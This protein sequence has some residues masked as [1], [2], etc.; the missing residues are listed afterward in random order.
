VR[1]SIGEVIE[2]L[3]LGR[4][5]EEYLVGPPDAFAPTASLLGRS[6]EYRHAVS[7]PKDNSGRQGNRAHGQGISAKA[8]QWPQ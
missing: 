6:G 4:P 5:W 2:Q 7:P 3:L 8:D 1:T